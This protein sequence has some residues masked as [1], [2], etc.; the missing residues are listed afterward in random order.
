MGIDWSR[1]RRP[2]PPPPVRLWLI[3]VFWAIP[4]LGLF[5]TQ[6]MGESDPALDDA[7][8]LVNYG[9]FAAMIASSVQ[10]YR[11]QKHRRAMAEWKM[12]LEKEQESSGPPP[13]PPPPPP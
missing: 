10:L 6:F 9:F 8:A 11:W 2:S 5:L 1:A 12:E 4:F 3:A 13:V 7:L